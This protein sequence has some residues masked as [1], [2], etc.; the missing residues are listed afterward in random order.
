[1][2]LMT[3]ELERAFAKQGDT[4]ELPAEQIPVVAKYFDPCGAGTWYAAEFD[5]ESR[6]FFGYVTGLGFDELGS[7]GLD[8]F[9]GHK[10]RMGL[11]IERDLHYR[12]GSVTLR[13]VMDGAKP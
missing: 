9:E 11:G 8:E 2:R 6:V 12:T 5:P 7:F 13:Q 1:M 4:A 10:G 3:K